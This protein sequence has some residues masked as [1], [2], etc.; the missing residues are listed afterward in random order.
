MKAVAD[1]LRE[2]VNSDGIRVL[3]VFPGRTATPRTKR[4]FHEEGKAYRPDL[5]MQPEDV[6]TMVVH[7]LK[8]PRTAEVTE[9][10]I[11]PLFKSY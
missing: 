5:L 9:I 4:L 10:M 11:R 6:A 3:C 8:M 2:E 7:A 1:S